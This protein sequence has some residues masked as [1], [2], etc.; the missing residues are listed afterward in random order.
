[1]AG[2]LGSPIGALFSP[3]IPLGLLRGLLTTGSL[4]RLE[5]GAF[6][7][8]SEPGSQPEAYGSSIIAPENA[9]PEEMRHERRHIEQSEALGPAYLPI[10]LASMLANYEQRPL[11]REAFQHEQPSHELLKKGPAGPGGLL[12]AL[13]RLR[14][15][16]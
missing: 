15:G 10:M 5:E 13:L 6:R 12:E 3:Q 16:E 4:P 8:V 1:M 9:A 11:E 14:L 7:F 2:R